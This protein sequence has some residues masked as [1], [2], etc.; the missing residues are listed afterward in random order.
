MPS[1]MSGS[2]NS[3]VGPLAAE[4]EGCVGGAGCFALGDDGA[5]GA[6]DLDGEAFEFVALARFALFAGAGEL[7]A[8]EA[9]AADGCELALPFGPAL[10]AA[11]VSNTKSTLPTGTVSPSLARSSVILPAAGAGT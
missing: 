4:R 10:A 7:G 2:L 3:I 1:P 5:D 9:F 11:P 8:R 6:G